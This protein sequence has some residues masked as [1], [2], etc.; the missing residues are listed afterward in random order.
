MNVRME[1]DK[2]KITRERENVEQELRSIRALNED[3]Y[4][5]NGVI[6]E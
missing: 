1:Q 2:V 6:R 3:L 5:Q 4:R